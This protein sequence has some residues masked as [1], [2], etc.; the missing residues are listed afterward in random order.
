[1]CFGML[2]L[3]CAGC[4]MCVL[5]GDPENCV[6]GSWAT[7]EM[8]SCH[9]YNDWRC[10]TEFWMASFMCTWALCMMYA[11][12]YGLIH[13]ATWDKSLDVLL[14]NGKQKKKSTKAQVNMLCCSSVVAPRAARV[15]IKYWNLLFEYRLSTGVHGLVLLRTLIKYRSECF[16]YWFGTGVNVSILI[17][18]WNH[19]LSNVEILESD[20]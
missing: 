2:G 9:Q 11:R 19:S 7:W 16:K 10:C 1:M 6:A 15:L 13:E 17:K 5:A 14:R 20:F 4:A 12:P 8:T 3:F 18:Y